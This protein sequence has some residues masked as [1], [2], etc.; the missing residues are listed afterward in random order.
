M[1][2]SMKR[3]GVIGAGAW[4][5]AL[6]QVCV[7]AGLETTLWAREPEVVAAIAETG[8]NSLFLPGVPLD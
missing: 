7:R 3:A 4:G 2:Q 8:E 5:T 1:S 6:A